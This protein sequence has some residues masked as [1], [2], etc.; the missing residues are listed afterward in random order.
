MSQPHINDAYRPIA[1][2]VHDRIQHWAVRRALLDVQWLDEEGAVREARASIDDVYTQGGAEW[3]R[4]DEG[5]VI[6]L[7]RLLRFSPSG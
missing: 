4:L 3:L 6:R 7:D 5:S 1:C 2:S